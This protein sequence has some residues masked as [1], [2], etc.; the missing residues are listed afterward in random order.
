MTWKPVVMRHKPTDKP[1]VD[2]ANRVI[3]AKLKW[4][5][6]R[7]Y[8]DDTVGWAHG[9]IDVYRAGG[10][11]SCCGVEFHGKAFD[12][13]YANRRAEMWMSMADWLKKGGSLP[14]IP[15]MVKEFTLRELTRVS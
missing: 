9:A 12:P 6:A 11:D 3:A 14:Y 13:R 1:S 2:I 5:Q 10:Y 15:E 7:E 8:F 4:K